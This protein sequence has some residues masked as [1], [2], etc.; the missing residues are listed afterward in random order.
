M[1]FFKLLAATARTWIIA[2]DLG[3][4]AFDL[5]C[6]GVGAGGTAAGRLLTIQHHLLPSASALC[7][8]SELLFIGLLF[9]DLYVEEETQS[10]FFDARHQ[11]FEQVEGFLLVLDQ[12]VALTVPAKAD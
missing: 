6:C 1:T 5:S 11:A 12:R 4:F 2:A 9:L 8:L 3:C 7:F 10:V